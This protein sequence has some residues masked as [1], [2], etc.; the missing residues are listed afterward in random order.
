M[1]DD[2]LFWFPEDRPIVEG[3]S[4]N[5]SVSHFGLVVDVVGAILLIG[6]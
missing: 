5:E 6:L 2:A 3:L 1:P 4:T